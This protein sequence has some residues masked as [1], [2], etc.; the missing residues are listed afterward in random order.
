MEIDRDWNAAINILNRGLKKIGQGL[1]ES[2]ATPVETFVGVSE[3][4]EAT[5]LVGW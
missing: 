1:P 2:I 5:Q 3:K 4:Q